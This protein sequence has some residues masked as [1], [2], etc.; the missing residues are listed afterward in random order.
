MDISNRKKLI[1]KAVVDDYVEKAGPVGSKVVSERLKLS[2]ATIRNEM[3]ELERLGYL[4]QPHTSAGRIP[5]PNGYRLYVDE[6]M[7]M[8]KL[9]LDEIAR[10]RNILSAQAHELDKLMQ[11]AG[12][13]IAE[14]THHT[15]LAVSPVSEQ[16][17][18]KRLNLMAIEG[19]S[20]LI[21]LVA[22]DDNVKNKIY[23]SR[24]RL[25]DEELQSANMALN[26]FFSG[27]NIDEITPSRIRAAEEQAGWQSG[28]IIAAVVMFIAE[29]SS[30]LTKRNIY[31]GGASKILD[32]PEYHDVGK[33]QKLLDLLYDPQKAS[34]LLPM[35]PT[36]FRITIGPENSE[37]S[38]YDASMVLAPYSTS[39]NAIGL[40]GVIGPTRM[41]Y[42]R[43]SAFL[44]CYA[45]L[46]SQLLSG[47]TLEINKKNNE[48]EE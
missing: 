44:T 6:L 23:R 37:E 46:I 32:Y 13:T 17:K 27:I 1:L 3:S 39:T 20:I 12:S 14:L 15:S 28:E 34:R 19:L 2:P 18:L 9:S 43:I 4:E 24:R 30:E 26:R 36:A 41:D 38:L 7:R 22:G 31:L 21:V 25:S 8:S 5:S 48:T 47:E 10:I 11:A 42:S 33:A 40:L 16:V 35:K 45:D 29:V